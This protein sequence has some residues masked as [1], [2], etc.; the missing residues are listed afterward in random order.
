MWRAQHARVCRDPPFIVIGAR[1]VRAGEAR[2]E[3]PMNLLKA[4]KAAAAAG[5][6]LPVPPLTDQ[7]SGEV[8]IEE[9]DVCSRESPIIV[10][11]ADQPASAEH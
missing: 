3:N 5:H 10:D 8:G 4:G 6:Q 7:S 1:I 11:P 2:Y 9:G